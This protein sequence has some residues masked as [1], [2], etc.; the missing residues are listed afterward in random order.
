MKSSAHDIPQ[1]K[2]VYSAYPVFFLTLLA[3]IPL[4]GYALLPDIAATLRW[5]GV[6]AVYAIVLA[7][8]AA[9]LVQKSQWSPSGNPATQGFDDWKVTTVPGAFGIAYKHLAAISFLLGGLLFAVWL[10]GQ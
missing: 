9:T 10:F 3:A 4:L 2:S 1:P 5:S 8:L 6:F 7:V